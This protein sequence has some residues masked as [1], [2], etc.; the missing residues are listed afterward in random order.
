MI[1]RAH[2]LHFVTAQLALSSG[3]DSDSTRTRR[4]KLQR[5]RAPWVLAV[6]GGGVRRRQPT[7]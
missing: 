5:R 2:E 7:Q 3:R 6:L 4:S 1:E